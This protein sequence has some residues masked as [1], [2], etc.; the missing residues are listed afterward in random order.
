MAR[1][2]V[3]NIFWGYSPMYDG[4]SHHVPLKKLSVIDSRSVGRKVLLKHHIR[5]GLTRRE[6]DSSRKRPRVVYVRAVYE[7]KPPRPLWDVMT[8][9][10]LH[11]TVQ[12]YLAHKKTQPKTLQ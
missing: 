12:G 3:V 5:P 11:G 2:P 1:Y 4:R 9:V 8:P 10:I 7:D 6:D